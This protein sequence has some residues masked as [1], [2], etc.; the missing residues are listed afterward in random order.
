MACWVLALTKELFALK[1]E[2]TTWL[3]S[4]AGVHGTVVPPLDAGTEGEMLETAPLT[5]TSKAAEPVR[6]PF[7]MRAVTVVGVPM[8]NF[9]GRR[10]DI[11]GPTCTVCI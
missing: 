3:P 7:A 6:E 10:I 2:L 5:L 8:R 1:V 4:V 11:A 9:E